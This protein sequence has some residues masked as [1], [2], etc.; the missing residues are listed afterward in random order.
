MNITN[1][2]QD[3]RNNP[4]H[5]KNVEN[6]SMKTI[7]DILNQYDIEEILGKGNFGKVNLGIHKITKEKVRQNNKL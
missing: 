1:N 2:V 4:E 6:N 7:E 3:E 5:E